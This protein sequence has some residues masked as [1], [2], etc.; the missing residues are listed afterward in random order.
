[1]KS[2]TILV[3]YHSVHEFIVLGEDEQDAV[4]VAQNGW[5]NLSQY[6]EWEKAAVCLTS[7]VLEKK[8]SCHEHDTPAWVQPPARH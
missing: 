1:M 5:P 2:Y 6:C 3:P 8:D 7:D 4:R